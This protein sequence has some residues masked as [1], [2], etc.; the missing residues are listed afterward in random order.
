MNNDNNGGLGYQKISKQFFV[1][2]SFR[3]WTLFYFILFY[4]ILFT[5]GIYKLILS[6]VYKNY[7]ARLT[8]EI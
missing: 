7:N 1:E 6:I 2:I 5:G 8:K 4:F 3:H